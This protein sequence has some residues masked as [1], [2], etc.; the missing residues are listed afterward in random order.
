MLG[1]PRQRVHV[2][3]VDHRDPAQRRDVRDRDDQPPIKR[4]DA[5]RLVSTLRRHQREYRPDQREG[6]QQGR[7]DD[8]DRAERERAAAYFFGRELHAKL[9]VPVG[10]IEPDWGGTRIESWTAPEGFA[11]V[12]ALQRDYEAFNSATRKV[13]ASTKPRR[14]FWTKPRTGSVRPAWP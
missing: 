7:E 6:R 2:G 8:A 10:L 4:E 13:R 11:A 12:P 9:G 3:D 1:D 14:S 5:R